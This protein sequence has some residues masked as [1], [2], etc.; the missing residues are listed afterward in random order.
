MLRR[1]FGR[2]RDE[3]IGGWRKLHNEE[4]HNLSSSPNSITLIKSRRMRRA[5][6]VRR[7]G[8][9]GMHIGFWWQKQKQGVNFAGLDVKRLILTFILEK[10]DGL[11]GS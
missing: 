5:W 4:L 1:I 8:R 9:Q 10:Q 11:S 3:A 7:A 6:H 2:K